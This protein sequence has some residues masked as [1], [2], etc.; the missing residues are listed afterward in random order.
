MKKK[1]IALAVAGAMTAPM[2]VMADVKISGQLQTQIVSIGGDHHTD[3]G[4]HM[5]DGGHVDANNG[6]NWGALSINASE[7]LGGGLKA[8]AHYSF[9]IS[10]DSSTNGVRQGWVGLAG[11]FGAVLAGRMNHP[12]KTSTIGYDPFVGTFMQARFNGGM[13][14]RIGG[15]GDV[16]YGTERDN[17]LAYAGSFGGAKVVAGVIFDE[18]DDATNDKTT[19]NHA[20]AASVNV[21]VGP[22]EVAV[23][24]A[25]LSEYAGSAEKQTA[26]KVG[27]KYAAG[28]FS[29]AGQLEM[30]GEGFSA[31]ADPDGG[32][33]MYV[34]GSYKMGA[35]TI[36][37]SVGRTSKDLLAGDEDQTYMAVGFNHAF[38]QNTSA[39]A[40]YRASSKVAGGDDSSNAV[41]V[42]MRVKF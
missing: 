33:V 22:V 16:L 6:G 39:F 4:I 9:N 27:V 11:D 2:A 37:A 25:S 31:D 34:T 21:P 41:G 23:A 30:L 36:S 42:G 32:N 18:T 10:T 20:Y 29:V 3:K 26:A 7:E 14:G 28:D 13:A 5:T 19:G 40:G 24:Y 1:L 8:L 38:S 12:Y 17:T 35:N 15:L